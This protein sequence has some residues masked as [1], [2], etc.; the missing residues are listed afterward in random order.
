MKIKC[1]NNNNNNNNN[2]NILVTTPYIPYAQQEIISLE[3]PLSLSRS[4]SLETIVSNKFIF[5]ENQY[6]RSNAQNNNGHFLVKA[7]YISNSDRTICL[8]NMSTKK[9]SVSISLVSRLF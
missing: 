9:P 8:T 7:P 1:L 5:Y 3:I 6:R 2:N 4:L